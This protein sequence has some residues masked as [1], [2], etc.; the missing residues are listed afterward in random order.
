VDTDMTV[1]NSLSHDET[2]SP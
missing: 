2:C 1:L